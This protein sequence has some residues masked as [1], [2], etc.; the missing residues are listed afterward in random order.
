MRDLRILNNICGKQTATIRYESKHGEPDNVE[1]GGQQGCILFQELFF[2]Y[3]DYALRAF[4]GMFGIS[5]EDKNVNF[6][7]VSDMVLIAINEGALQN[8]QNI[9]DRKSKK[10][11]LRINL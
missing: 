3:S 2:L 4:E 9:A 1:R 8:I 10:V 5:V 11:D 6:F 7:F